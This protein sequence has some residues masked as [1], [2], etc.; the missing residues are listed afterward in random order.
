MDARSQPTS[1]GPF[2]QLEGDGRRLRSD[3]RAFA[4]SKPRQ[5][6]DQHCCIRAQAVEEGPIAGLKAVL[7]I[8]QRFCSSI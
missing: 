5:Y 3:Q 2:T 6:K 1:D 7:H 8:L 4:V